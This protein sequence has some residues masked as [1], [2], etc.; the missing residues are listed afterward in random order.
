MI[1]DGIILA[2]VIALLRGGTFKG[3]DEIK[4][5]H[6]IWIVLLF[7]IQLILF[8]VAAYNET[9]AS[10]IPFWVIVFYI[11]LLFLGWQN[12]HV[13]GFNL[14]LLGILLNMIV[15]LVNGGKMPV[16]V[17][18]VAMVKPETMDLLTSGAAIKH[19][20]MNDE[21]NLWFLGDIIPL[22]SPYPNQKV[23]SLG[24]VILNVGGFIFVWKTMLK[25]RRKRNI[26]GEII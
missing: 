10:W 13:P 20:P 21:T 15:M 1:L 18:A 11:F 14:M 24:D 16:S 3:F 23:I 5:R 4:F 12:R 2:V 9:V 26:G 7:V 8:I 19:T 6:G 17:E 25:H 22:V